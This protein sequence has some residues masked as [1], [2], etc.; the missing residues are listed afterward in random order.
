MFASDSIP[1]FKSE[2]IIAEYGLKKRLNIYLDILLEY[3]KKINLV[4]RETSRPALVRLAAGCLV[5]FK[6][7]N[8]PAGTFFDI[9][10]GGG[11]PAIVLLLAFQNLKGVMYERT[12][13]KAHF[14][15]SLVKEM[16]LAAEVYSD[17][18]PS[19]NQLKDDYFDFG[20]LKLVRLE[21]KILSHAE[22][23]LKPGGRFI[24]YAA[25]PA[26]KSD[27]GKMRLSRHDYFLDDSAQLRTMSIFLKS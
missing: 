4:S 26:M 15:E 10:S 14:L 5:P 6:F 24:Y 25:A 23:S 27:M 17:D 8:P 13:K 18:W 7:S 12:H 20:T 11:F 16:N 22:S 19:L 3:N 9:G 1:F 2:E 21:P